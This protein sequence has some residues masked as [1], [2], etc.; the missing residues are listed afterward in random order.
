MV[1]DTSV[2]EAD[3]AGTLVDEVASGLGGIT[4]VSSAD[5]VGWAGVKGRPKHP[6]P[7]GSHLDSWRGLHLVQL[8]LDFIGADGASFYLLRCSPQSSGRDAGGG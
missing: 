8:T 7:L 1:L 3:G 2:D 5:D 4:I 6:P